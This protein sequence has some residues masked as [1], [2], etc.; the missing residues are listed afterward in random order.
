MIHKKQ[1]LCPQRKVRNLKS[2][3]LIF[4]CNNI[5]YCFLCMCLPV[6]ETETETLWLDLIQLWFELF[7][8]CTLLQ[9]KV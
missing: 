9:M 3:V 5:A 2:Q 4:L 6:S 8:I 1:Q 7:P